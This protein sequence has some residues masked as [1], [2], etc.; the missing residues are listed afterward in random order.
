M[1]IHSKNNNFITRKHTLRPN[2]N[3]FKCTWFWGIGFPGL[4]SAAY[5]RR[6]PVRFSVQIDASSLIDIVQHYR[7][8]VLT[9]HLSAVE[10]GSGGGHCGFPV[11]SLFWDRGRGY[12]AFV[13]LHLLFL[14]FDL[15]VRLECA[16]TS[17]TWPNCETCVSAKLAVDQSHLVVFDWRQIRN[18]LYRDW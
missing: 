15:G 7:I 11:K 2:D 14:Y 12:S 13:L 18:I 6:G 17:L 8:S 5:H 1:N 16:V 9:G 3:T 4:F 10:N